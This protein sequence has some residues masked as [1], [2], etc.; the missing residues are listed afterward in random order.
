MNPL[1]AL[2]EQKA[3]CAESRQKSPCSAR[4]KGSGVTLKMAVV[5]IH[6]QTMFCAL[7]NFKMFANTIRELEISKLEEGDGIA[8]TSIK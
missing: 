5:I 8:A 7:M 2:T 4:E 6:W 1:H 3:F